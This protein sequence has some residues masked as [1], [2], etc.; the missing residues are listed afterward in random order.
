MINVDV[1]GNEVRKARDYKLTGSE[2]ARLLG[3]AA[4]PPAVTTS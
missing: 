3:T 2:A 1:R 4:D